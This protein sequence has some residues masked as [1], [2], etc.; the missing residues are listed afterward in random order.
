MSE[1]SEFDQLIKQ[2]LAMIEQN[3]GPEVAQRVRTAYE[4]KDL[5]ELHRIADLSAEVAR[6]SREIVAKYQAG[7]KR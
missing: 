4:N 3:A 2:Y 7:T 1:K 5:D 6:K